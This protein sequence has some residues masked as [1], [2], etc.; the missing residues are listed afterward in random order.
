MRFVF[1][2]PSPNPI[3]ASPSPQSE[4]SKSG[5]FHASGISEGSDN[6]LKYFQLDP[7]LIKIESSVP[8]VPAE[9]LQ[10]PPRSLAKLGL[11]NSIE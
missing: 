3:A 4:S 10:F 9:A 11:I 5:D 2:N 7:P 8:A 1:K 6:P